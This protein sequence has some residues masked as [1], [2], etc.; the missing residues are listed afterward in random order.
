MAR[1]VIDEK[2][3][4]S[5]RTNLP[6][7]FALEGWRAPACVGHDAGAIQDGGL[8]AES[9]RKL[10]QCVAENTIRIG[11][12]GAGQVGS[13]YLVQVPR[14][15]DVHLFGSLIHYTTPRARISQPQAASIEHTQTR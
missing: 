7:R 9:P 3:T 14:T 1:D 6:G 11:L 10:Q 12:I 5:V 8:A 4:H 15:S 2:G 13:M